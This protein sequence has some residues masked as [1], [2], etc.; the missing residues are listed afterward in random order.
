MGWGGICVSV[1]MHTSKYTGGGV[2]DNVTLFRK[3]KEKERIRAK[4]YHS[5]M[6]IGKLR[7]LQRE[8]REGKKYIYVHRQEKK[9]SSRKFHP[10][11]K[12]IVDKLKELIIKETKI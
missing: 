8:A 1:S 4:Q 3:T 5:G 2:E 12:R 6:R 9:Y 11:S 7:S 10:N